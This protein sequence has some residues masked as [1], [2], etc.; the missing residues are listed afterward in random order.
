MA[1]W[2]SRVQNAL[3]ALPRAPAD[4]D[5]LVVAGLTGPEWSLLVYCFLN[6]P[7]FTLDELRLWLPYTSDAQFQSWFREL[8]ATLYVQRIADGEFVVTDKGASLVKEWCR[9]GRALLAHQHPLP[10]PALRK[11]ADGLEQVVVAALERPMVKIARLSGSRRLVF[12]AL[13]STMERIDQALAD[14]YHFRDDCHVAAWSTAGLSGPEVEV[15]TLLWR[16][17]ATDLA[18]LVKRLGEERGLQ[19]EEVSRVA[20]RLASRGSVVLDEDG[21]ELTVAGRALREDIEAATD[22]HYMPAWTVLPP[23]QLEVLGRL[24]ARFT[25]AMSAKR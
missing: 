15:L 1:E 25:Q 13:P 23:P 21:A 20:Q 22:R 6:E 2:S 8:L 10:E 5:A 24:L 11:L 7:P 17:E 12:E 4:A 18:T 16:Q 14:L 9:L 3:A 19:A